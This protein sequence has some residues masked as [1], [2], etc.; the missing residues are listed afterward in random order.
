[1][2]ASELIK[3]LQE[4]VDNGQDYEVKIYIKDI[5]ILTSI[6]DDEN[7]GPYPI[8]EVETYI[9]AYHTSS[10]IRIDINI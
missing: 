4:Y 3:I 2:V 10:D 1:M 6:A 8:Q 5:D 7:C 9:E